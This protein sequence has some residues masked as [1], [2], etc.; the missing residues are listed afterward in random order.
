[1]NSERKDLKI[2]YY[3]SSGPGGQR[4][5][6]KETAVRIRHLPTGITAIATENRSQASNVELALGRIKNRVRNFY[7]KKKAR[8]PTKVS[9]SAKRKRLDEKTRHKE[10]KQ[11]RRKDYAD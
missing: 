6:K 8:I 11:L 10:K 7:R 2:D 1:M 4:K 3:R 9:R 5:N